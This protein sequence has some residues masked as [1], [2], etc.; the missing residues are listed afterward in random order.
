MWRDGKGSCRE[1]GRATIGRGVRGE[2]RP[3]PW[4]RAPQSKIWRV[5]AAA[6]WRGLGKDCGLRKHARLCGQRGPGSELAS[7]AGGTE[8]GPG[9]WRVPM[10][11]LP[12]HFLVR[13]VVPEMKGKNYES[14][15]GCGS[16]SDKIRSAF[17][18]KDHPGQLSW[19][20]A[21]R[22][23]MMLLAWAYAAG[24]GSCCSAVELLLQVP[25]GRE[26]RKLTQEK[27]HPGCVCA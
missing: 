22:P 10:S 8:G 6:R 14:W 2:R 17:F 3:L 5:T 24:L 11:C 1:A 27:S 12:P 16:C 19:E 15:G 26:R 4:G 13:F 18:E 23:A 7:G 21:G 20:G 25:A 9:Q